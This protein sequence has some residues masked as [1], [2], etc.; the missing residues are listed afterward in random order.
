MSWVELRNKK[1]QRLE[2]GNWT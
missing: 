1:T 2:L